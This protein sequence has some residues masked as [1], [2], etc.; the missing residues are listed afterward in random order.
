MDRNE[1]WDL[2]SS[3]ATGRD[4]AARALAAKAGALARRCQTREDS[5]TAFRARAHARVILKTFALL[6][7]CAE[8]CCKEEPERDLGDFTSQRARSQIRQARAL[9]SWLP[10]REKIRLRSFDWQE[11]HGT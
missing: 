10:G 4:A 5:L 3:R 11:A 9:S 7:S 1:R 6:V 8:T 2:R